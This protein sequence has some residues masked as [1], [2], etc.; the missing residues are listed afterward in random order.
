MALQFFNYATATGL[1]GIYNQASIDF[2][3]R[4][5]AKP[6]VDPVEVRIEGEGIDKLMDE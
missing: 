3:E 5:D 6:L 2:Y 4:L 1:P